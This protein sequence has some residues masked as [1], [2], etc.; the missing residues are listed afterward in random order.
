MGERVKITA[1]AEGALLAALA[2]VLALIGIFLPPLQVV[3]NVIWTVPITV[4]I[5]RRDLRT[6]ILATVVAGILVGLFGSLLRAFFLFTQFAG[7]GL[8]YGYLFKKEAAPGRM[9]MAG[10]LMAL[11]SLVLSLILSFKLLG[12]APGQLWADLEQ[13]SDHI[14]ELYRRSGMLEGLAK[15]GITLE[16]LRHSVESTV[17][18]IKLLLPAM[19]ATIALFTAFINYLVAEAVLQRLNLRKRLLPPFRYWQLPWYTLWGVIAGLGLWLGGDYWQLAW[20]KTVGLNILYLY[21]PLLLGNGLAVVSF[22]AHK[23]N[24]SPVLKV[25]FLLAFLI[26]IPLGLFMLLALGL[27]DP[28]LGWRKPKEAS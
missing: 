24:W 1:L 2:A 12:L 15:Q 17:A 6:G 16:E 14:L 22:F 18:Y 10:T 28:F 11:L 8:L 3:T 26:Y 25:A 4:L 13:T 27:F 19:L 23:F 7:T 5:V 21:L 20:L 9:V